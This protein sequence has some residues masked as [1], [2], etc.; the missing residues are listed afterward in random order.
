MSE[1]DAPLGAPTAVTDEPTDV[2]LGGVSPEDA[3]LG[4]E[5][6]EHDVAPE[7]FD[8]AE[9]VGG[10]RPGRRAVT[11]SPRGDLIAEMQVLADRAARATDD[12]VPALLE[13]YEALKAAYEGSRRTIVVEARSSEWLAD[14]HKRLKKQFKLDLS[15]PGDRVTLMLRQVAE[16][17]VLPTRGVTP[18]ALRSLYEANEVEFD[19]LWRACDSAN[20]A[21]GVVPDFPSS[22]RG[23]SVRNPTG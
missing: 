9:F 20:R 7:D 19:K 2:P 8:F 23:R 18:E 14:L 15:K 1:F 11:L 13:E 16:Q 22:S 5:A 12:D 4:I 21:T 10:A 17:I 3:E 6:V